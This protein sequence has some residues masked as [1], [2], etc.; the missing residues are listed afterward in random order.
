MFV[1]DKIGPGLCR[2]KA[3]TLFKEMAIVSLNVAAKRSKTS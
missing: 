1:W 2:N 3:G